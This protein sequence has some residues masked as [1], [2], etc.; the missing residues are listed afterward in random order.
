MV[1]IYFFKQS[2]KCFIV[3][4]M[5]IIYSFYFYMRQSKN[6]TP[7][8]KYFVMFCVLSS[9][10]LLYAPPTLWFDNP[11]LFDSVKVHVY[12]SLAMVCHGSV[13]RAL[14]CGNNI[15]QRLIVIVCGST[16]TPPWLPATAWHHTATQVPIGVGLAFWTQRPLCLRTWEWYS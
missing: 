8:L 6:H 5:Y 16:F 12:V 15:N 10:M 4:Y 9:G 3:R 1:S 14:F 7:C 13:C 11:N 2:L